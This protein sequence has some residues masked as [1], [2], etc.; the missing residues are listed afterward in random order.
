MI[1]RSHLRT[2][3]TPLARL[4]RIY[5]DAGFRVQTGL[6][7]YHFRSWRDAPFTLLFR[8]GKPV[9]TGGGGVSIYE[10]PFLEHLRLTADFKSI[11]I[12][13]NSFGW[14]TLLMALLW[15]DAEVVAMD[16]GFLPPE[17]WT[18]RLLQ[19]TSSIISG[20]PE[21]EPIDP[22]F[23]INL[24]NQLAQQ[25]R[26]KA[27][28]IK[29]MSPQDVQRV[30]SEHLTST[31]DFVFIDGYHV[32]SQVL[33]DFDA[34]YKVAS[35]DAVYL[36]HDVINWKLEESFMKIMRNQQMSGAILW[37]TMSGMGFLCPQHRSGEFKEL[38]ETFN[39]PPESLEKL[40]IQLPRRMLADRI[41]QTI[42]HSRLA[43]W[44]K[45]L[46]ASG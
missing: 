42:L 44:L 30:V 25:H 29:G 35:P 34:C 17:H 40:R 28:V 43:H 19:R 26:L 5:Q 31:P 37:R 16:C 7:S 13:G 14:S 32:P 2:L 39:E 20:D 18:Q 12:V 33:L 10:I 3:D 24:T 22:D 1:D 46:L 36:F 6:N 11:F 27:R 21:T 4:L 23:G 8:D 41:I 9:Q 15:P 45:R 38:L